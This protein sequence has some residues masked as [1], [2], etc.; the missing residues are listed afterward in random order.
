M[1]RRPTARLSITLRLHDVEDP[2]FGWEK[3]DEIDVGARL[4]RQ[5]A[6]LESHR[7]IDMQPYRDRWGMWSLFVVDLAR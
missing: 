2:G 5:F 4:A 7:P 3:H 6:E 1:T